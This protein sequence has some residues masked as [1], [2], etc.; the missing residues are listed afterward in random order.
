MQFLKTLKDYAYIGFG[1]SFASGF[2]LVNSLIIARVLG[3]SNFGVFS[4]FYSLMIL[5]WQLPQSFDGI[6]VSMAKKSNAKAD[7]IEYLKSA[8]ALKLL[9]LLPLITLSYPLA[10]IIGN[11]CF[12]K[13]NLTLPLISAFVCGSLLTFLSTIASIFQE[14]ER[15]AYF[16]SIHAIYTSSIFLGLL[17]LL[18]LKI[19]FTLNIILTIYVSF[20]VLIGLFSIIFLLN[21][22]SSLFHINYSILSKSFEQGKWLFFAIATYCI[23][24][25][26]DVLFLPRYVK[27]EILGQYAVAATLISVVT[28]G[29]RPLTATCLPKASLAILSKKSFN[30]FVK[31][32]LFAISL[33]ELGI[34]LYFILSP[35]IVVYFYG[36][37]YIPSVKILRIILIGWAF[38]VFFIPFQFI[39]IALEDTKT[40]F[41]IEFVKLIIAFFLLYIFVPLYGITGAAYA[42]TLTLCSSSIISFYILMLRLKTTFKEHALV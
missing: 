33:I 37:Q 28:L 34:V 15:Y 1:T 35:Y 20:S 18:I 21:K 9:Y 24:A 16:A 11:Y 7:K 2:A 19:K 6:F 10:Y 42:I 14:E 17:L 22:T 26:I 4:I 5:S 41:S 27:Y 12:G 3:P 8:I 32:S 40:H 23:F 30:H 25:R 36:A 38:S 13:Q 31:E 39:F 29:I